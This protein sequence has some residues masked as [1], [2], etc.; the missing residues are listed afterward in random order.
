MKVDPNNFDYIM[1]VDA[2]GDDGFKFDHGST[3]CYTAAAL[4]V[5][6]ENIS[7]NLEILGRIK[8]ILGCKQT[9]EI[10]YS[11]VRRHRRGD[12]ALSLL[13]DIRGQLSCYVVFKKE[14]DPEIYIGNKILSVVCHRMALNS[15]DVYPFEEGSRVLIA[16]D[17]MKQTEEEPLRE[18]LNDTKESEQRNFDVKTV[19]RDSKDANFLLIQIADLL[20]GSLREHFEQYETQEDMLYFSGKCPVCQRLREIKRQPIRPLCKNGKSRTTKIINS[21]AFKYIYPLFPATKNIDMIDYFFVDPAKM[22]DKHFY[23]ICNLKK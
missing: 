1:Y 2:S 11:R 17:R 8:S 12:E 9:D 7:H 15:I 3:T 20:C 21:Q 16:I 14:V 22:I 19:F 18:L 6:Q 23:M 5:N 13:R 4:L 10:K